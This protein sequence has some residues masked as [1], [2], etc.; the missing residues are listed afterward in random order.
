MTLEPNFLVIQAHA[1]ICVKIKIK[2]KRI[3]SNNVLQYKSF[4]HKKKLSICVAWKSINI[5]WLLNAKA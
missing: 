1:Q 2:I 3:Q 4:E 5:S